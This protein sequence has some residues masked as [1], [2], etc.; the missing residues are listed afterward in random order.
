MIYVGQLIKDIEQVCYNLTVKMW[1][2]M[3][4]SMLSY[5]VL[6]YSYVAYSQTSPAQIEQPYPLRLI[7]GLLSRFSKDKNALNQ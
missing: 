1:P 3:F 7:G 4:G 6:L 2:Y 5:A